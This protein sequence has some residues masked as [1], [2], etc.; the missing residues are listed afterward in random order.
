[1]GFLMTTPE[2]CPKCGAPM[3]KKRAKQGANKGGYF[4][5]CPNYPGCK[6]LIGILGPVQATK[7]DNSALKGQVEAVL[8]GLNAREQKILTMRLGIGCEPHTLV[9]I[10]TVMGISRERVRQLER[11]YLRKVKKLMKDKDK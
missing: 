8:P 9:D 5:G 1:M 6:G 4:W 3:I 10:G 2:L 11:K 7:P